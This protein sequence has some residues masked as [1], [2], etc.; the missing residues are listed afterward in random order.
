MGEPAIRLP[1]LPSD[2]DLPSDFDM[3]RICYWRSPSEWWIYLPGCTQP[4]WHFVR[5][6]EPEDPAEFRATLILHP[7]EGG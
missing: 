1:D 4:G 2:S 3:A 6:G 7:K 5:G